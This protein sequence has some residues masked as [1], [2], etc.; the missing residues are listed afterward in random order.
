MKTNSKNWFQRVSKCLGFFNSKRQARSD[1]SKKTEND[2]LTPNLLFTTDLLKNSLNQTV[3]GPFHTWTNRIQAMSTYKTLLHSDQCVLIAI[4]C[5][6][7]IAGLEG[8]PHGS[9]LPFHPRVTAFQGWLEVALQR[10]TQRHWHCQHEHWW[11]RPTA[12]WAYAQED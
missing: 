12:T 7:L 1:Y 8:E 4:C 3:I 10:S 2:R 6:V 9:I 11:E 5:P